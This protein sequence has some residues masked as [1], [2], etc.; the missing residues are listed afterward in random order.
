MIVVVVRV[1][2]CIGIGDRHR[3]RQALQNIQARTRMVM[4][5]FLGQLMCWSTDKAQAK[6]GPGW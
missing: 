2:V 5:Y 6:Q 4:A 3:N 1:H